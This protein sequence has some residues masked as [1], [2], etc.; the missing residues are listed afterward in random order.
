MEGNNILLSTAYCGP[1]SYF[2]LIARGPA[3]FLEQHE[4]FIKQTFRNRCIIM[5]PNGIAP[6]I[7]PVE[8]GK[9]Q[10][11]SIR[12]TKIAYHTEWQ[13]IHWRTL[14]SA[15][16]NSPF[17]EYYC[18]EIRVFYEKKWTFL[19][20]FNLEYLTTLLALCN[21]ERDI[22]LT[23]G[24]EAVPPFDN[25]RLSVSPKVNYSESS[26]WFIP[27]PYTQVFNEKFPFAANLSILD[28]LFNA[29]PKTAEILRS[30]G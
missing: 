12:E 19:F 20:D 29:G 18:D 4:N 24:F 22:K 3:I 21:L 8:H 9:K 17:F 6:L 28:L 15:Y 11:L 1:V 5:S 7:I 2:T 16:N 13:R 14:F 25:F 27:S 10:K 30:K 26:P 23:E